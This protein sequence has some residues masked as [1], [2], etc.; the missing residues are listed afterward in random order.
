MKSNWK[1]K[2]LDE[3]QP[4]WTIFGHILMKVLPNELENQPE[5]D[6]FTEW[7]QTFELYRGKQGVEEFEDEGRVVG[8]FKVR[9]TKIQKVFYILLGAY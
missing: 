2:N 1:R 6:G 9:I 7:L 4:I 8:K 3:K 5:F